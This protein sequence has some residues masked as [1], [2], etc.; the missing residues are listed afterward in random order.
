M[1]DEQR[2][3]RVGVRTPGV[4]GQR[5]EWLSRQGDL[6]TFDVPGPGR[7]TLCMSGGW[8]ASGIAY[9][10]LGWEAADEVDLA[11]RRAHRD[12]ILAL[13]REIEA[14]DEVLDPIRQHAHDLVPEDQGVAPLGIQPVCLCGHRYDHHGHAQGDLGCRR[15]HCT[16]YDP[17]RERA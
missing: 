12:R 1:T 7:V 14:P 15:C 2:S 16:N 10:T 9:C 13:A 4:Q 3:I 6:A 17:T 11:E 5:D 8:A